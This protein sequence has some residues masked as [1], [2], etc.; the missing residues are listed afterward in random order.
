MGMLTGFTADH[1]REF[2][3]LD[4]SYNWISTIPDSFSNLNVLHLSLDHN[5][6][7]TIP[8]GLLKNPSFSIT[9]DLSNNLITSIPDGISEW[10]GE[11]LILSN[12]RIS[13][14]P[15]SMGSM[16]NPNFQLL[17][18][19]FNSISYIPDSFAN[20]SAKSM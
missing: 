13:S 1:V 8:P 4:L 2:L 9:M 16:N 5:N 10:R 3:V 15:L 18:L 11:S 14:I 19:S 12:N 20:C 17:D 7:S 6:L